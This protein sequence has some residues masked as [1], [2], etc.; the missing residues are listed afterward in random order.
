MSE[1]TANWMPTALDKEVE[2]MIQAT[3][4]EFGTGTIDEQIAALD[5][6]PAEPA[7]EPVQDTQVPPVVQEKVPEIKAEPLSEAVQRELGYKLREDALSAKENQ[8]KALEIELASLRKRMP[9]EDLVEALRHNTSETLNSMGL[10]PDQIVRMVLAERMGD[11]APPEL[12][13]E[14]KSSRKDRELLDRLRRLEQENQESKR[15]L[16]ARQ[17]YDEVQTGA[18]KHVTETGISEYAPTVA[19]VAKLNP[20]RVFAEIMEEISTDA[21]IKAARDPGAPLMTYEEATKRVERR[22]A[23]LSKVLTPNPENVTAAPAKMPAKEPSV[24]QHQSASTIKAPDRPLAP[25]LKPQTDV[26]NEGLKAALAEYK[27]LETPGR[28]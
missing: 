14:I 20:D 28:P 26:E 16:S 8:Y 1:V 23:D 25:W 6:A 22:W 9:P 19:K 13:N 12:A 27:R 24:T 21:Q 5:A 3:E 17:F 11:S 18:R 4:A 7:V 15:A 2:A 10:D